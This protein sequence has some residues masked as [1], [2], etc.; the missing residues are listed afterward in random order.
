MFIFL[1][2]PQNTLFLHLVQEIHV[3]SKKDEPLSLNVVFIEQGAKREYFAGKE[4]K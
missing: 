2:Y 3:K 4:E 1:L